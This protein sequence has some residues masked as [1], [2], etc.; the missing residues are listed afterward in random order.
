MEKIRIRDPGWKTF[1]SG[2]W[3]KHSGSATL[4]TNIN[5]DPPD[6][7]PQHRFGKLGQGERDTLRM[8]CVNWMILVL[9]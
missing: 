3:D 7:D 2:I 4:L 8:S 9:W 5:K 6:P 1:G